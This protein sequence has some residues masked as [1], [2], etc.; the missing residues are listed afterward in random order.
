[1]R[2]REFA[3]KHI[4]KLKGFLD[5]NFFCRNNRW[6]AHNT[7]PFCPC[8]QAYKKKDGIHTSECRLL[9]LSESL[10]RN[11]VLLYNKTP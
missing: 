10:A 5:T 1:M 9:N 7:L 11:L 8:Y 6:R 3:E 2:F 4:E